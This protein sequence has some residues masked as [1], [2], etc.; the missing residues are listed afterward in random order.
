MSHCFVLFHSTLCRKRMDDKKVSYIQSETLFAE[1]LW[2]LVGLISKHSL[3][4][5][6][7][8]C[9]V[10]V[11][12]SQSMHFRLSLPFHCFF[13]ADFIS[14][15]RGDVVFLTS[16]LRSLMLSRVKNNPFPMPS[17]IYTDVRTHPGAK[18]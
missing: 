17:A 13:R 18:Y 1:F 5:L 8:T 6:S 2:S 15:W 3:F 16:V 4:L 12:C 10:T 7:T 9:S 14:R 11:A